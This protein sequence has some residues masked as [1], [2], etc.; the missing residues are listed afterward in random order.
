MPLDAEWLWDFQNVVT[1]EI[2]TNIDAIMVFSKSVTKKFSPH[3]HHLFEERPTF[4]S[5]AFWLFG[6]SIIDICPW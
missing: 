6:E 5:L 1:I 4:F 3:F 2:P